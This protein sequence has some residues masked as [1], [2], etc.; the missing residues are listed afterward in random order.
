VRFKWSAIFWHDFFSAPEI[1][2]ICADNFGFAQRWPRHRIVA[3]P[4]FS[5]DLVLLA[6]GN[7]TERSHLATRLLAP[8]VWCPSTDRSRINSRSWA[9]K[10]ESIVSIRRPVA[11]AVSDSSVMLRTRTPCFSNSATRVQIRRQK[12]AWERFLGP[13]TLNL[14]M[15]TLLAKPFHNSPALFP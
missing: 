5:S 4:Q 1:R 3:N 10:P 11:V 2:Q 12:R 13:S 14:S 7:R 9:A 8:A 15:G 6:C